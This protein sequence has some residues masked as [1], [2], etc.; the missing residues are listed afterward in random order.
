MKNILYL[1]SLN[2][3]IM[4]DFFKATDPDPDGALDPTKLVEIR[5]DP[6]Q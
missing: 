5:P 1:F 3:L 4:C 2:I 6:Q